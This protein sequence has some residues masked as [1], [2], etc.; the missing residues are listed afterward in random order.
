MGFILLSIFDQNLRK[1]NE[2][3]K[4]SGIKSEEL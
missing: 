3:L 1:V 2:V 4:K